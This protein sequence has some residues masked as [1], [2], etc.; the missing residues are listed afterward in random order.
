MT[1]DIR[2]CY[3]INSCLDGRIGAYTIEIFPFLTHSRGL[4]PELT[5]SGIGLITAQ[6][7]NPVGLAAIGW[8]Y[9]ILFCCILAALSTL[10]S[11]VFPE[12]KGRILE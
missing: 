9:R 7:I 12:T 3:G 11:L 2:L 10:I 1:H 5:S 6:L 4:T 8:E